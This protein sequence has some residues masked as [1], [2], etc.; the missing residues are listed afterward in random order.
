MKRT[1]FILSFIASLDVIGL[2]LMFWV[3]KRTYD[4]ETACL[5]MMVFGLGF[6]WEFIWIGGA[7]LRQDWLI[8]TVIGVC[9]LK[10]RKYT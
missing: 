8:V 6:G 5:S 3:I 4:I 1:Y 10:Q 7:F 2:L 9:M